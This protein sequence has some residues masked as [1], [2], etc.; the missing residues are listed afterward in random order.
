VHL[1]GVPHGVPLMDVPL[2]GLPL[3][4]CLA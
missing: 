4:A 1:I 3:V 2:I